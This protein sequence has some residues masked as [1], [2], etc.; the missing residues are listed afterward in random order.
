MN[1]IE[2]CLSSVSD[3]P[4][5]VVDNNSSDNTVNYIEEN[6][7]KVILIKNNINYG[8]A[9]ANNMGIK[10]AIEE[11]ADYVFL[12]NHDAWIVEGCLP[13]LLE[14]AESNLDHGVISPIH[15]NASKKLLEYLFTSFIS[16]PNDEGRKLYSDLILQKPLQEIYDVNFINAAA[17]L[18]RRNAVKTVG[19]FDSINFPHYGE[20]N[21]YLQ[22]VRYYNF[23]IGVVPSAFI[24]HD[25]ESRAGKH[26][27]KIFQA[28]LGLRKFKVSL[29]DLT[30]TVLSEELKYEI[31]LDLASSIIS[32]LKL[33]FTEFKTRFAVYKEKRRLI[34]SASTITDK[35]KKEGFDPE[36]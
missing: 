20:D 11:G 18:I 17:W 5:V 35:Y 16:Q 32:L 3:Y 24:F 14:V 25:T 33:N 19:L 36:I 30:K 9:K 12:L 1:W 21:N 26:N 15:L 4:T 23:K 13:K 2:K 28:H 22:R 27:S 31:K 10:K 34:N 7:P 8:F 29:L 6:Y